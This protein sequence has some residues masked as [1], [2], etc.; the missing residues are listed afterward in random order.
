MKMKKL[1][2]SGVLIFTTMLSFAT[3]PAKDSSLNKEV[4]LENEVITMESLSD[5]CSD[6]APT[7]QTGPFGNVSWYVLNTRFSY[8]CVSIRYYYCLF[9]E[10]PTCMYFTYEV[11][12]ECN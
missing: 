9:K 2:L 7:P 1:L 11:R 10:C 3:C 6:N 5:Y 12:P 4:I 8:T